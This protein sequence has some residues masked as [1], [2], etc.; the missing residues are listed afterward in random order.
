LNQDIQNSHTFIKK[1]KDRLARPLPGEKAQFLMAPASRKSPGTYL[2]NIGTPRKS[3]VLIMLY[4]EDE[5]WKFPIIQRPQNTGIH[6]GQMALP[7]GR[8]E[9]SDQDRIATALRE[10][11]EE[12]GILTGKI[13]ILGTLTELHVAASQ[14]TVL[15]VVAF[16]PS[17]PVY[18]PDQS[19]VESIHVVLLEEIMDD[20]HCLVTSIPVTE[21][22]SIEAPYY[23]VDRKYVWGATAM[24]LSEFLYIVRE[25]I[26]DL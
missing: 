6:S 16:N 13:R 20:N 19:E 26:D 22:I 21:N 11:R 23:D 2:K 14:N 4:F 5:K 1:L 25:I 8:M 12:I 3:S 15:P 18:K 9:Q 24:I 17:I 10:T 7:G